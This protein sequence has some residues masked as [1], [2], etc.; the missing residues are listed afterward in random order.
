MWFSRM[1]YSYLRGWSLGWGW[2]TLGR[3]GE[4]YIS[5]EDG[6]IIVCSDLLLV[7]DCEIYKKERM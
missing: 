1:C 5:E 3:G 2:Q 4:V 7:L 6:R